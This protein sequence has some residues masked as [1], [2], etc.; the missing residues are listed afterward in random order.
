MLLR[1]RVESSPR[2]FTYRKNLMH[3]CPKQLGSP[4][5]YGRLR[6]QV[7][8]ESSPRWFSYQCNNTHSNPK[9]HISPTFLGR[10][11]CCFSR[12]PRVLHIGFNTEGTPSILALLGF[13]LLPSTCDYY[14]ASTKSRGFP[15]HFL[16]SKESDALWHEAAWLSYFRWTM[17]TSVES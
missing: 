13:A 9:Q 5:L 3:S 7:R 15:T 1:P 17:M 11:Y 12:E 14:V 8:V 6:I 10:L 4:T 2:S 16:K